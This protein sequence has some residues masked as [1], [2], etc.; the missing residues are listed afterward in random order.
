MQHLHPLILLLTASEF[1]EAST[2]EKKRGAWPTANNDL[3]KTIS[4]Q[5]KSKKDNTDLNLAGKLQARYTTDHYIKIFCKHWTLISRGYVTIYT[6]EISRGYVTIHTI[7]ISRGYVTI[8]TIEISRGYVTIYTIE[9]LR[10]YVT[11]YTIEISR[12]YVT[13]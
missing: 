6:I 9:I 4:S 8:Y 2:F 13:I 5:A 12:D 11:I 7:K 10:G 3:K 1:S